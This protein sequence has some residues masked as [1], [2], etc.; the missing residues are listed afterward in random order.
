MPELNRYGRRALEHWETQLPQEYLGNSRERP[1][2]GFA[3]LGERIVD[4]GHPPRPGADG[5]AGTRDHHGLPGPVRPAVHPPAR[6]GTPI[7]EEMLPAPAQEIRPGPNPFPASLAGRPS[8]VLRRCPD[9]REPDRAGHPPGGPRR[10]PP[11]YRTGAAASPAGPASAP[12]RA[13]ST[14][15]ARI[16]PRNAP[17]LP[18]S[19]PP[20]CA[21]PCAAPPSTRTTPMPATCRPSGQPSASSDSP[22]AASWSPAADR[23]LH[24]ARSRH[25]RTDRRRTRPRHRRDR[26]RAL[27]AGHDPRRVVRRHQPPGGLL[28]RRHRQRPVRQT[29]AVRPPPQPQAGGCPSTITS[30]SRP[31]PSPAPAGSSPC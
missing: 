4:G 2:G 28:R 25:R 26:C 14:P 8:P 16:S 6:R 22:R 30:W 12:S 23:A 10:E 24:S 1:A 27:P 17:S 9:R 5:S 15:A 21:G 13:S 20:T 19:P 29:Q 18:S 11:G 7:L 31:W 3:A